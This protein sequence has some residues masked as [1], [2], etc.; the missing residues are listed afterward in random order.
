MSVRDFAFAAA[1]WGV[2]AAFVVCWMTDRGKNVID[3]AQS[4]QTLPRK[5]ALIYDDHAHAM[6]SGWWVPSAGYR[7]TNAA[8]SEVIFRT[9]AAPDCS[10]DLAAFPLVVDERH[11][12]V[13][14]AALNG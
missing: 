3:Y 12:Q 13:A 10:V 1:G 11:S 9:D 2:L 4:L 5:T 6:W 7:L 8:D 14:Y